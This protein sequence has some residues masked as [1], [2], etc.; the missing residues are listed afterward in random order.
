ME[1]R[2]YGIR[3]ASLLRQETNLNKMDP[4]LNKLSAALD[5]LVLRQKITASNIANIDTE[6]YNK[7][8]VEFEKYLKEA[9]LNGDTAV[10]KPS[11]ETTDEKVDL[12]TELIEMAET[13]MKVQFVTRM[14]RSQLE[15]TKMGITGNPNSRL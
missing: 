13:Q 1:N 4:G 12:D 5:A 8:R 2:I 7:R 9:K 10:V 3:L 11:I 14:I 15:L 6:G